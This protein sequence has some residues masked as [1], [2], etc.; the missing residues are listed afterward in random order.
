MTIKIS[1]LSNLTAVLANVQIP[2]VANVAGTLTT[3]K[4]NVGQL[5]DYIL[6][7]SGADYA[8][9]VA[10]AATQAG[11]IATLTSNAAVQ[12]GAIAD[13]YSNLAIKS[14]EIADLQANAAT[15]AG[16]LATLT[17][18]AAAQAGELATL[19]ANA[20]AQSGD[21]STLTGNAAVQ[22]GL[23]ATLT[24]NAAVQAGELATLTANAAAQAGLIANISTGIVTFGNVIPSANVTY[25]LGSPSAQWKDLY[26][27]GSTI[28]I[29]GAQLSVA[30]GAVQSSVPI[31]ADIAATTLNVADTQ[32]TFSQGSFIEETAVIGQ[33]GVYGLA[34]NS[35]VDG[36]VGLN[37][38]DTNASVMSSVIVSNVSVQVNVQ[39][40]S[41]P[42]NVHI[43]QYL[44]DGSL[45]WPDLTVQSTAF[46][47]DIATTITNTESNVTV[48]QGNVNVLQGN[49]ANIYANLGVVSGNIALLDADVGNL[50]A[51]MNI[52]EVQ[53]A[54]ILG[55][56]SN[57]ESNVTSI[58]SGTSN[59]AFTMSNTAHWT[60]NVFTLSD[61]IN[62]LAQRIYN[63]ENP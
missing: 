11:Q 54:F 32:I 53:G 30:N 39:N 31:A 42:A 23:L 2:M 18:N 34:L 58:T 14:G 19:T 13:I 25:S 50:F 59:I 26:L 5:T 55:N 41:D 35:P 27:S 28:Y 47:S 24:S 15:Q 52:V 63:I 51:R 12:A 40:T 10:N 17:A 8:N 22:A 16:Q 45:L 49:V 60:S 21:L 62:Q 33:P 44:E 29:G 43:W 37:A 20:G 7:A 48:L 4:G 57:L 56:I 3:V 61:A 46:T 38:L 9:I 36:I 6:G 1:E